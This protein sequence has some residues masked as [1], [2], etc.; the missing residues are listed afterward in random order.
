MV[1]SA[2]GLALSHGSPQLTR[3]RA[4]LRHRLPPM[5]SQRADLT[6]YPSAHHRK[7][8][9]APVKVDREGK[10]MKVR[11]ESK[12]TYYWRLWR[13][14][15]ERDWCEWERLFEQMKSQ[16][17]LLD[18]A[19]Y[20]LKLHGFILSHRHRSEQ[21]LLILEEMKEAKMHP[22]IIRINEG[23]VRSYFELQEMRCEA[24]RPHWQNFCFI[25]WIA[26]I[27]FMRKR[28]RRMWSAL[29]KAR[30]D[31]VL[32][33]T[34]EVGLLMDYQY[35]T[36]AIPPPTPVPLLA[37]SADAADAQ[38]GLI[39]DD[40][41]TEW[42]SAHMMMIAESGRQRGSVGGHDERPLAA[43]ATAA[44]A[45]DS[46]SQRHKRGR[47][48]WSNLG[49][50]RG[51]VS[52][53]PDHAPAAAAAAAGGGRK[54]RRALGTHSRQHATTTMPTSAAADDGAADDDTY[55]TFDFSR[56]RPAP[57]RHH[58]A[59]PD[60]H[61]SNAS[62]SSSSS[63]SMESSSRPSGSS[64]ESFRVVRPRRAAPIVSEEVLD[65]AMRDLERTLQESVKKST[66]A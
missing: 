55:V 16:N 42:S 48:S 33:L 52:H 39:D 28:E 65:E 54:S 15:V 6:I 25:S 5:L 21:A 2:S 49:M 60:K 11:A 61:A 37:D 31:D 22:A 43:A 66:D 38:H 62:S 45:A 57:L 32:Q 3:S 46:Q 44:D 7:A 24:G 13:A 10:H 8:V 41:H 40:P 1:C 35:D 56:D 20:T 9:K 58:T 63:S 18:E 64:F 34:K 12:M 53:P 51:Q 14:I 4:L 17:M 19:T 50:G 30:P 36:A 29:M 23:L 26:A 59:P 47:P 27:N